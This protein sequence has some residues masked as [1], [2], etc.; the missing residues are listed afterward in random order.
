MIKAIIFDCFGVLITDAL[1]A[2]IGD[3]KTTDPKTAQEIVSL[4]VA[5]NKGLIDPEVSRP[6]IAKLLGLTYEEYW[7]KLRTDEVKDTALLGYIQ[8]LHQH[9][10]IGLLSNVSRGGI[11]ARF[12]PDELAVF[13]ALVPSGD[14]G[15]AKPSPEAYEITADRLGVRYHECLMIDDREDY[16]EGAVAVGMQAIHYLSLAQLK[17][18]LATR[19]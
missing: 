19:L 6:A 14:T 15:F 16:C 17:K 12:T 9:Y 1:S 13:D 3:L 11:T 10:K 7:Q 5:A 18:E 8:E 2:M 4:T